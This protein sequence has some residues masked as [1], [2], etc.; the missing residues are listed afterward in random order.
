VRII[1]ELLFLEELLLNWLMDGMI[2]GLNR[3][4]DLWSM[5]RLI[6]IR[7]ISTVIFRVFVNT[8]PRVKR[9]SR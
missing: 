6:V 8:M 1:Q 3:M 5:L 9:P 4:I 7:D 2:V